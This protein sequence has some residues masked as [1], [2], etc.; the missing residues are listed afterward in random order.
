[1]NSAELAGWATALSTFF[2]ALVAIFQDRIRRWV[3]RPK[4]ELSVRVLPPDCHR[5]TWTVKRQLFDPNAREYYVQVRNFP[6][7]YFRVTITNTGRTEAREVELFA[8]AL[9]RMRMDGTYE[10]VPRFTPMNL[11][12]SHV[13]QPFLPILSPEIPKVCDLAHVFQPQ[14]REGLGHTLPDVSADRAILAFDLQVEPNMKGHLAEPGT[15]R[16]SL[17]LAAANASP[18][19]YALQ[20]DFPGDWYD[21]EAR[22]LRD[23]FG[24]RL[25]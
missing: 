7:Y 1:M 21:D 25:V 3:M 6:C 11:M 24:M 19:K 2:L 18:K 8:A 15:Y 9:E 13:R 22:M 5:T 23:G 17:T 16:L 4:L 14:D 12:W 20:I 10:V